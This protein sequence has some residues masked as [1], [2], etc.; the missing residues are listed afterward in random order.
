MDIRPKI[1][2]ADDEIAILHVISLKLKRAGYNVVTAINGLAAYEQALSELPDLI[3]T[4][5]HMPDLSGLELCSKLKYNAATKE[6]PVLMLTSH[7]FDISD[8][9][10]SSGIV[11]CLDK[12]FSPT[13]LLEEV[14]TLTAKAA[15]PA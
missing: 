12:P 14:E 11:K 8:E 4:D 6:I 13:E 2:I 7:S 3:I 1:L 15:I 9:M 5:Y 10:L